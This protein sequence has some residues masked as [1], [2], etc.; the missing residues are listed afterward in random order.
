[1]ILTIICLLLG[2]CATD[3]NQRQLQTE[4]AVAS[5]QIADLRLTATVQSA[6]IQITL[7][8]GGTQVAAAQAR[9]QFIQAT[10]I[11]EGFVAENLEQFEQQFLVGVVGQRT[12]TT[13]TPPAPIGSGIAQQAMQ[14]Q[15]QSPITPSATIPGVTP[16]SM[17]QRTATPQPTTI[18]AD[19]TAPRLENPVTSTGVG[20]DDC[21]VNT[22]SNFTTTT[23]EIYLVVEAVNTPADAQFG[24]RWS[25]E[26]TVLADIDFSLNF[27]IERACIWFF[28]DQ[29]DFQFTP[30]NYT[31]DL[32][33]NGEPAGTPVT[34]VIQ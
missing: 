18:L 13:P 22:T 19:P 17:L 20:N 24:S 10:L 1:M 33:L 26:G 6:R 29:T 27:D 4:H 28:V 16:M 9:S 30:G 11:S 31:V 12:G 15:A 21:A 32:T 8:Y 25:R 7:D 34:F 23:P 14:P 3:T 2:A 5:T